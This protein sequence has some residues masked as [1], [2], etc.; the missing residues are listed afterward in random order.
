MDSTTTENTP[1]I[2]NLTDIMTVD[3]VAAFL[4]LDRKT[5]YDL[6]QR[7]EIKGWKKVGRQIRFSKRALVK[8]IE[9]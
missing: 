7:K 9:G 1:N 8:W 4:R 2:S 6:V 5:V 3:E